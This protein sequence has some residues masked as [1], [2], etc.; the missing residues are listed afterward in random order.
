MVEDLL[1]RGEVRIQELIRME[2]FADKDSHQGG[3]RNEGFIR[4]PAGQGKTARRELPGPALP[5]TDRASMF[6]GAEGMSSLRRP[7][8]EGTY[9]SLFAAELATRLTE[10]DE[11]RG[12]KSPSRP[13][14]LQTHPQVTL[15]SPGGED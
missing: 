12:R 6:R 15:S 8:E 7:G 2:D 11:G 5:R 4:P 13:E 1:E 3:D 10:V 14:P 9:R